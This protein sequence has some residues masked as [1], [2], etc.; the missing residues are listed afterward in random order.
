MPVNDGIRRKLVGFLVEDKTLRDNL[1]SMLNSNL[2]DDDKA[3]SI[4][5][6][7]RNVLSNSVPN[8]NQQ[9]EEIK[10]SLPM[11]KSFL[12]LFDAMVEHLDEFADDLRN[13]QKAV[14]LK[15]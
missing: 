11:I 13:P 3:Q 15:T 7:M 6:Q 10:A 1:L 12:T 14:G 5:D 2:S 4:I 9:K 8:T